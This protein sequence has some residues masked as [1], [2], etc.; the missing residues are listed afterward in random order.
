MSGALPVSHVHGRGVVSPPLLP[1]AM[2]ADILGDG[3]PS[4]RGEGISRSSAQAN[5]VSATPVVL[6]G[7]GPGDRAAAVGDANVRNR[8]I[9]SIVGSG[10]RDAT[11][12][13][14]RRLGY[15]SRVRSA[16]SL[17]DVSRS[18]ALAQTPGESPGHDFGGDS[19]LFMWQHSHKGTGAESA[20]LPA[21]PATSLPHA[22]TSKAADSIV[23]GGQ[24]ASEQ[25]P[26]GYAPAHSAHATL[27]PLYAN[28]AGGLAVGAAGM[29]PGFNAF[30][31]GV[32]M[33]WPHPGPGAALTQRKSRPPSREDPSSNSSASQSVSL[34]S[35]KAPRPIGTRGAQRT[36]GPAYGQPAAPQPPPPPHQQFAPPAAHYPWQLHYA[37]QPPHVYGVPQGAILD[38]SLSYFS[39]QM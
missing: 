37:V 13:S 35:G 21:Q 28:G 19:G 39:S 24:V 32:G 3:E 16:S 20:H 15:G 29:V 5:G 12:D 7:P 34:A 10:P 11:A 8:R 23:T 2:L 14:G 27:H 31:A 25:Q 36:H 26:W 6:S 38:N 30:S 1:H 18:S 9:S 4:G 22:R 17:F 33:A